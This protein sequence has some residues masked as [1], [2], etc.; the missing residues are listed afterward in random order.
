M[1]DQ[2]K[3]SLLD[4]SS[5][6]GCQQKHKN[7]RSTCNKINIQAQLLRPNEIDIHPGKAASWTWIAIKLFH[8]E[9]AANEDMILN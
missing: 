8:E 3:S 6:S 7:I 1:P 4:M 9:S 5:Y 2:T